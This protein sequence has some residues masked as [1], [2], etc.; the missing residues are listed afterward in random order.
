MMSIG[1]NQMHSIQMAAKTTGIIPCHASVG[2]KGHSTKNNALLL[3]SLNGHFNYL[4]QLGEMRV[5]RA[6]VTLVNGAV[7]H[8]NHE[9][10]DDEVYLP[11]LMGYHN[12]CR[13]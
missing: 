10:A 9:V 5:T 8:N 12:C 7:G 13:H 4:L 1:Y 6:V 3:E 2:A 11:I